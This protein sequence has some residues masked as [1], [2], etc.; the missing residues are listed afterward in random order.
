MRWRAVAAM[1]AM[2]AMAAVTVAAMAEVTVAAMAEVMAAATVV[3]VAATVTV[4][5]STAVSGGA[6]TAS[7][8]A[9]KRPVTDGFGFATKGETGGWRVPVPRHPLKF[10]QSA[11]DRH[12]VLAS[13]EV[14][15]PR[16]IRH[17]AL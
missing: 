3:M 6:V 15:R 10:D 5:T 16:R 1:A 13:L 14:L 17:I 12:P 11:F 8:R 9:G 2:A 7:A 4:G